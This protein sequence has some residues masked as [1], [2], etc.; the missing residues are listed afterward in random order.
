MTQARKN[1]LKNKIIASR[2]RLINSHPFF[3]I[4]LMYVKFYA[5]TGMKKIS[6]NGI[7]IYFSP[8]FLEKLYDR[9]IDFILSH[10][11]MHIICEHI[12]RPSDMK[13]DDYHYACDIYI[14][15]LLKRHGFETDRYPHLG[16][17]QCT[18]H[19]YDADADGISVEEI[20][21]AMP[22]SLYILDDRARNRFFADSDIFWNTYMPENSELILDVPEKEA[23]LRE[24]GSGGA[25][26]E[27][28]LRILWQGRAAS[29]AKSL[30]EN[31]S[32]AGNIPGFIERIING[33][34]KPVLDWKKILDEFVQENVCD[35]SFSPPD[36]RFEDTG[37]FL[38]D[39]NDREFMPRDVLFMADTSGSI[40][41]ETLILVYS[42]IKGA[43]EQFGSRLT[44]SLGFFDI[45][46]T[47]PL[48]FSEVNDLMRIVPR[49]GGGTDFR[50]IFRFL[51]KR[52]AYALPAC[53]IIF[54]DGYGPYP[55]QD[56][57]LGIPVLWLITDSDITP[58]FGKTA[59]I[60]THR[61]YDEKGE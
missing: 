29:A 51:R 25:C 59:R 6:T 16:E 47:E 2:S 18:L 39:F 48:P 8:D 45:N 44:G 10:Q 54:T 38:P 49:G 61:T 35:Y 37:F 50:P 40:D 13:G 56:D 26:D 5:V 33:L 1:R 23:L 14:N 34:K 58:P 60:S 52:A 32:D 31:E 11:I 46:V 55:Q 20:I 24:S 22:F 4:M 41:D 12:W 53:I 19:G 7:D 42:E 28:T 17:I 3:A 36:R 9:E 21:A 43:I 30:R 27:S 15:R 57:T